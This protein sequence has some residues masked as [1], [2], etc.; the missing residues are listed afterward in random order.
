M[1]IVR[2]FRSFPRRP[3]FRKKNHF[4]SQRTKIDWKSSLNVFSQQTKN[5]NTIFI[6]LLSL[7]SFDRKFGFIS[8][9]SRESALSNSTQLFVT[10]NCWEQVS[11]SRVVLWNMRKK[12]LT[13]KIR[14][15]SYKLIYCCLIKIITQLINRMVS[16]RVLL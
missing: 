6:I 11:R 7:S 5:L 1:N 12:V 16:Q 8:L 4:S 2:L 13:F 14:G 15:N 10:N 9:A 3:F